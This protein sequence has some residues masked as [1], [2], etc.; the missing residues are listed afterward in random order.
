[1]DNRDLLV[2]LE[3][4]VRRAVRVLRDVRES[5]VDRAPEAL[6]VIR[7]LSEALASPDPRDRPDLPALEASLVTLDRL[8]HQ[9]ELVSQVR[10]E[11]PVLPVTRVQL[12]PEVN[13]GRKV[14]RVWPDLSE[15]PESVDRLVRRVREELT[16]YGGF[17][18]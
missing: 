9:V 8:V 10:L 12:E 5:R 4:L 1:M 15:A 6:V 3:R 11:T 14:H 13:L 16:D 17:R 18:A 7:D 2:P